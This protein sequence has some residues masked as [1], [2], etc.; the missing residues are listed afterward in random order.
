MGPWVVFISVR[1][2]TIIVIA[3]SASANYGLVRQVP[4]YGCFYNK[5]YSD[6][7]M[8]HS[9][10]CH[11]LSCRSKNKLGNDNPLSL[12]VG[13]WVGGGGGGLVI[14]NIK[15]VIWEYNKL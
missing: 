4:S 7:H 15:L 2:F 6:L 3:R 13:E 9:V 1:H 14:I 10:S 11:F 5:T 8:Y 12:W